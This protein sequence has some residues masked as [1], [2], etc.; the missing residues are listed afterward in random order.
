MFSQLTLP[1]RYFDLA[2]RSYNIRHKMLSKQSQIKESV[3][4]CNIN[5]YIMLIIIDLMKDTKP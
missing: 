5:M 4:M 2:K 3:L 1:F